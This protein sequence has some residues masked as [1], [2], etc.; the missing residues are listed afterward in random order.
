[1]DPAQSKP[2][3][4]QRM[5]AEPET[6]PVSRPDDPPAGDLPPAAV[7]RA[8]I[9]RVEEPAR[10]PAVEESPAAPAP[11][12]RLVDPAQRDE[13][14][15]QRTAPETDLHLADEAHPSERIQPSPAQVQRQPGLDVE[16]LSREYSKINL[17]VLRQLSRPV[18]PDQDNQP[19]GNEPK[20]SVT[21]PVVARKP[22]QFIS[23]KPPAILPQGREPA[24]SN[25]PG[26]PAT[27]Q[28]STQPAHYAYSPAGSLAA[29]LT[30]MVLPGPSQPE[31]GPAGPVQRVA[32]S[33]AGS[34][35]VSDG[36]LQRQLDAGQSVVQ[37]VELAP[38]TVEE[39]EEQPDLDQLARQVYPLIK[40]MLA[41]ERERLS[42]R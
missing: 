27:A 20:L 30:E 18:P 32:E 23:L 34:Q 8:A 13:T 22:A 9:P 42:S 5:P 38:S 40:R 37:R 26:L 15:Q 11:V 24:L 1:M 7:Q 17:P 25:E 41:I 3:L 12:Q 6:G 35:M 10:L 21:T 16:M 4:I 14:A 31:N 2:G 36:V 19:G 33:G 29:H 28:R 39:K